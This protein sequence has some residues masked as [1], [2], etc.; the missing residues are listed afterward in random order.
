MKFFES[1]KQSAE[2]ATFQAQKMVRVQRQQS[3]VGALNQAK[4]AA[5][6][7]V[8]NKAVEKARDGSLHDDELISLAQ[9]VLDAEGKIAEAEAELERIRAEQPP[10]TTGPST[11]SAAP[12]AT[13]AQ[14]GYYCQNCGR[15]L[16]L[17]VQFCT[18]CGARV[19]AGESGGAPDLQQSAPVWPSSG[20]ADVTAPAARTETPGAP[21]AW[22]PP[23][24]SPTPAGEPQAQGAPPA[25]SSAPPAWSSPSEEESSSGV[26]A[27]QAQGPA[28]AW[29][30]PNEV[31]DGTPL[32]REEELDAPT[33]W[34][35][36]GQS[37]AATSAERLEAQD[38]QTMPFERRALTDDESSSDESPRAV[39]PSDATPAFPGP[40]DTIFVGG[41]TSDSDPETM[42]QLCEVCDAELVAGVAFCTNC[43]A[44]V[45]RESENA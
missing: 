19:S 27:P 26:E 32:D 12:S 40:M 17:G 34:A 15:P 41:A 30:P 36:P 14:S 33:S 38:E 13:E 3:A 39:A 35:T 2:D 18:S 45:S 10:N 7:A 28:P 16:A 21:P 42:S 31:E 9:L 6:R 4:D 43:G 1:I 11:Q 22:T 37:E 25:W 24:A 8:G 20:A 5:T 29:S 23:P 44:R